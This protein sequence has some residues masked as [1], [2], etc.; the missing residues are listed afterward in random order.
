MGSRRRHGF[1]LIELLVVIAIIA[2]LIALLLPAVQA[3]REAARRSQCIN[4]LKQ[5]GLAMHNYHAAIGAFP[6]GSSRTNGASW[7]NWSAQGLM[8][9]YMEQN[10]IYNAINFN[11]EVTVGANTTGAYTTIN[12][13]LCPSD[14]NAGNI[15]GLL[16]SYYGSCGTTTNVYGDYPQ[17]PANSGVC[18]TTGAF[19]YR[20]SYSIAH[21]IDGTSNT[22]AYGE[23]LASNKINPLARGNITM[24]AGLSGD[25]FPDANQ[26][27]AAVMTAL[28]KCSTNYATTSNTSLTHGHFWSVGSMSTTL[29]NTIVTPNNSQYRWGACRQDCNSGC[30]A[31]SANYSNLQSNHSGGVNVLMGDGSV[32]FVKDSVAIATYWAIGTKANGE[33]VDSSGY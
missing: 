15:T 32:K 8:L 28:Q 14:G 29:F 30:D 3:A 12:S 2:V 31:A 1:T 6:M 5:I 23:G 24:N 25:Q 4:N 17:S 7:N 22:I 18:Q 11:L 16:N 21:F 33:V 27:A 9:P 19:G 13:F 26:G 10:A 20:L